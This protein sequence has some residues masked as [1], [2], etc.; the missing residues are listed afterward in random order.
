MDSESY[1]IQKYID[2]AFP[3]NKKISLL[4]AGCG[5]T[6]RI[7]VGKDWKVTGIDISKKQ[8][9]RNK[10]LNKKIL[11]DIQEVRLPKNEYDL[12][13]CWDVLE[14]LQNPDKALEN[15]DNSIKKNGILVLALP[16]VHSLKGLLTKFTPHWFHIFV[17]R[18]FLGRKDAGKNDTAPFKTYL[19]FS[20]S[21]KAIKKFAENNDYK[22]LYLNI[23]EHKWHK[24]LRDKIFLFNWMV[25]F[26]KFMKKILFMKNFE[27]E[28]GDF[29]IILQKK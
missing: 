4:E 26:F 1:V 27:P 13:L 7:V 29:I 15:F 25:Y 5:S 14:H 17:Y 23:Y 8:L 20:I 16:N 9:D 12:I 2:K 28:G 6:S 11:G 22:E 21:P 24:R 19:R 10:R 3:K 18:F